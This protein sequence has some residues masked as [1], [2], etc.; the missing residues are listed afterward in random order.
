MSY[1]IHLSI[2]DAQL[3]YCKFLSANDVGLTGGHQSGPYVAKAAVSILFDEPCARGRNK[4]K[5][6]KIHWHDDSITESNFKYYGS[7]TRNEYRITTFGRGF[8]YFKPSCIGSL[9]VLCKID[10]ETYRGYVIED[11]L[12]IDAFLDYYGLSPAETNALLNVNDSIYEDV[13]LKNFVDQI[14]GDFPSTSEI[15][16]QARRVLTGIMLRKDINAISQPDQTLVNWLKYEYLLFKEIEKKFNQ[17]I[18]EVPF[19]SIDDFVN[20]AN[21]MLN[22]R[23]SRAGRSLENHLSEVFRINSLRFVEQGTTEQNKKP[24][25]LFP[26]ERTYLDSLTTFEYDKLAMLAAKTTCKDRWRQILT[27]AD[28]IETKHLFTLQQG[29]SSNQLNEMKIQK[30]QLVVP[31]QYISTYPLEHR[32]WIWDLSKFV[33]FIKEKQ[34]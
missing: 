5:T 18:L 2:S 30:V 22:R 25:F 20:R 4:T 31:K 16:L 19:T 15:A 23:K 12:E 29:I 33:Q 10:C 11:E 17:D 1:D 21:S 27:E 3:V 7:G 6:V 28:K 8:P 9:F 34:L 14:S 32:E 26:D 24:D 13:Q